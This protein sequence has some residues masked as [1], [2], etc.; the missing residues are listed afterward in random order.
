MESRKNEQLMSRRHHHSFL[1]DRAAGGYFTLIELLVVIAIIAILAA[2]LMPALQQARETSRAVSCVN[3]MK[4]LGLGL[5]QY[6]G[7]NSDTLPPTEW[8]SFGSAAAH[9]LWNESLMGGLNAASSSRPG[10]KAFGMIAQGTYINTTILH[11]PSSKREKYWDTYCSYASNWSLM[12]R[13]TSRKASSLRSPSRKI[14]LLETI[15]FVSSM[16]DITGG[17][18]RFNPE[19][20]FGNTQWG[21]P[22]TRHNH[23]SNCLH[24]DG[25]VASYKIPNISNPLG[26]FPFNYTQEESKPY[27]YYNY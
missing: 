21:Y 1:R 27:L 19:I 7:D 8:G 2:M 4:Q 6:I 20:A 5:N 13:K 23:A 9:P 25:H 16:L 24:L 14:V 10:M 26:E 22:S 11:C 3:N 12:G 17:F 18:Y 15:R